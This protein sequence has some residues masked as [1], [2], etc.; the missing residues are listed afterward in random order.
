ML[1]EGVL[2]LASSE[3]PCAGPDA[4]L[5]TLCVI[6]LA[7]FHLADFTRPHQLPKTLTIALVFARCTEACLGAPNTGTL[8]TNFGGGSGLACD[9]VPGRLRS[10]RGLTTCAMT[11][12]LLRFGR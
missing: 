11:S 9:A 8:S 12:R 1:N 4:D 7:V 5:P 10:N 2:K 6:D 3:L